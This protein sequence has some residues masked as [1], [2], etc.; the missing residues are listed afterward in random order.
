MGRARLLQGRWSWFR[1]RESVQCGLRSAPER[2]F[3]LGNRAWNYWVIASVLVA[4]W[5]AAS[6]KAG[7]K[8]RPKTFSSALAFEAY[9]VIGE[10]HLGGPTHRRHSFRSA[11]DDTAVRGAG[12]LSRWLQLTWRTYVRL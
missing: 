6:A 4:L 10:E 11:A 9:A 7:E 3:K 12:T 8:A 5:A 1:E 2:R